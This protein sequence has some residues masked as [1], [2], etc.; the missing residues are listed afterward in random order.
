MIY[1][2]LKACVDDLERHG[3]LVRIKEEM[4]PDLEM[5]EIQRRVYINQGP[6]L[7]F[8]KVKGSGW[9][10]TIVGDDGP[11]DLRGRGGNDTIIG[12]G[13]DDHLRGGS[14]DDSL[15]GGL[16]SDWLRGGSGI[17]ECINGETVLNCE[18]PI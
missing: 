7:F 15:D 17:D 6:A 1:K 12:G 14:G 4:E 10:D 13:G 2:S 5:A 11:N 18:G 16:G 8:E 9:D 3:H